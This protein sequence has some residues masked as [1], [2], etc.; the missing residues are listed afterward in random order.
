M[1]IEE[2]KSKPF[3]DVL[4]QKLKCLQK[5]TNRSGFNLQYLR[6]IVVASNFLYEKQIS[7]APMKRN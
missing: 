3:L 7:I 4:T 2:N 1:V 5:P 6:K